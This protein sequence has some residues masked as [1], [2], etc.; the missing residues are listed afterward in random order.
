MNR[1]FPYEYRLEDMFREVHE[2]PLLEVLDEHRGPG[3]PGLDPAGL[4]QIIAEDGYPLAP[5]LQECYFPYRNMALHWRAADSGTPLFGEFDVM[6]IVTSPDRRVPVDDLARDDDDRALLSELRVLDDISL[7]GEGRLATM[8]YHVGVTSPDIWFLD[9]YHAY[10][11]LDLDYRAYLDNLLVT[12]GV[13][14][15]QYLFADV[16][17]SDREYRYILENIRA[18]LRIFPEEFP[19]HNYDPLAARLEARL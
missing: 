10:I 3:A 12:K 7:G 6:S 8:R 17:L 19:D 9:R 14:G 4:F 5:G 13:T 16:D 15:W 11:R 2:S 18:M 1:M